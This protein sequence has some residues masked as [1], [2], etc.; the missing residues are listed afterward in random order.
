M[1][2]T[3]PEGSPRSGLLTHAAML[4]INAH[5]LTTSPTHRGK[6][7]REKWLCRPVPP[8]PPG[9][10]TML[11][12]PVEGE[13][14]V[15]L[16]DRLMRHRA[17]DSCR[18]CHTLMDDVGLV[19][20]GFDPI[21]AERTE[22]SGLPVVTTGALD[23]RAVAN[24]RELGVALAA[25]RD[26]SECLVRVLLRFGT[27]RVE[28][29]EENGNIQALTDRFEANGHR[30]KFLLAELPRIALRRRPA[31]RRRA[32][33]SRFALS[34][35]TLLRGA[36]ASV[37]LPLLEAMLNPNG[38]A[39]AQGE[40]LPVR[41]GVFF[42]GNGVIRSKSIPTAEGEGYELTPESRAAGARPRV[43]ERGQRV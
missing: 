9:V 28:T 24:P 17:S 27:G 20:E 6:F 16:R 21:G 43:R 15:T 36:G 32:M 13:P 1:K 26:V 22:D 8:P 10:I 23:G 37:A 18:G 30:V 19:L 29:Y 14:A 38:T 39:L 31:G 2:A 33:K 25:S 4:S 34:R 11:P 42:F 7:V 40:P 41:F 5:P 35:R 3:F 12:D